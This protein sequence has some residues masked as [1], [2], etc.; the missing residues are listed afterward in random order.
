MIVIVIDHTI[1]GCPRSEPECVRSQ[2]E[3]NQI[4]HCLSLDK[5]SLRAITTCSS[6]T[7]KLAEMR[8]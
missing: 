7:P 2:I 3:K 8:F 5:T 6:L 4:S 1:L